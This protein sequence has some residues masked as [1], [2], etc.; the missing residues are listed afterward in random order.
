MLTYLLRRLLLMF[1]TL[2]G[3][4]LVVF[5]VMA[6][7]PGGIT[8]ESL[9]EG[10]NL[11][12]EAKKEITAYYNRLYGLDDP[13]WMQYLRWLNNASPIGFTFDEQNKLSGFSF[14]KGS[15][16]GKSF[17][18]GRPVTDLLAERV[19]ITVLLNVLSIPLVYLLALLVGVR[20][21]VERGRSFDISSGMVMLGLWS[22]PTML[23]GVLLIGFFANEQ[24]WHWFPTA[25]LSERVVMDQVFL[26]HWSN[27]WDLG[28]LFLLVTLSA[29]LFLAMASAARQW[30]MGFIGLIWV[31]LGAA[32]VWQLPEAG[33]SPLLWLMIP[34]AFALLAVW[35]ASTDYRLLRQI[36]FLSTSLLVGLLLAVYGMQGEW[37]RGFLLDRVWHLVL[38]VVCL[39]YG[40]FAGLAK[41][42]RTAVLENLL[43]DYARTARAKGLAESEVLWRHVFRN[44]LLP[45]ITVAASLLPSLLAGSVIVESIFS[46][47]GMGKLAVE[48]VKG[49]DRELVLS[50]TLI[51][52]ML[53]LLGYLL[54]D[55]LY[56]LADP[57]VSYD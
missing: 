18:Y 6:S 39:S 24:Y 34:G 38:P 2:L 5:V 3:I 14:T 51:G 29:A 27:L 17:R 42:T 13:A 54:A 26:P 37:L 57:R 12:P 55:F 43:S 22:V 56:A 15:D 47:D 9:V 21:A 45:L 49:R 44:S 33:R 40:G 4:T 35:L 11:D 16:L 23:A 7:S 25:G 30:R 41:L 32:M 46:I 50:I 1:P 19:P 48:A 36:G 20:A 10:Q 52:G 31:V 8:A 28:L 53:T